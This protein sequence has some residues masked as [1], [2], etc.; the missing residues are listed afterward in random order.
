[1]FWGM[2][3]RRDRS[4]QRLNP[5]SSKLRLFDLLPQRDEHFPNVRWFHSQRYARMRG[6]LVMLGRCNYRQFSMQG[7]HLQGG[8]DD[9]DRRRWL[10]VAKVGQSPHPVLNKHGFVVCSSDEAD[11]VL[12]A[13][14]RVKRNVA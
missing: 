9:V 6:L 2:L 14:K 7:Q 5:S 3:D 11:E 1:M 12:E 8:L 4:A 10:A 13:V